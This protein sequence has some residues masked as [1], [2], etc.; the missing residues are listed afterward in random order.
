VGTGSAPRLWVVVILGAFLLCLVSFTWVVGS[1]FLTGQMLKKNDSG[2]F[3]RDTSSI[4]AC[5]L[6][7]CPYKYTYVKDLLSHKT[8]RVQIYGGKTVETVLLSKYYL[9]FYSQFTCL[10]N[11]MLLKPPNVAWV[12]QRKHRMWLAVTAN[13]PLHSTAAAVIHSFY[14]VRK[15]FCLG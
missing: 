9:L 7:Y 1:Y 4:I 6:D 8:S 10:Q 3:R 14:P 2:R 5:D 12:M 13:P 15:F 11:G